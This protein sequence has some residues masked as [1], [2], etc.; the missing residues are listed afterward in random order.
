MI[1]YFCLEITEPCIGKGVVKVCILKELSLTPFAI[2]NTPGDPSIR[3][4]SW[5]S[6][7][8]NILV[9]QPE[10]RMRYSQH[11]WSSPLSFSSPTAPLIPLPH[12]DVPPPCHPFVTFL[13][14]WQQLRKGMAWFWRWLTEQ[15]VIRWWP[16]PPSLTGHMTSRALPPQVHVLVLL[17]R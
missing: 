8:C 3:V 4:P 2:I 15:R 10:P 6:S 14:L 5:A 1:I 16:F 7:Y 9:D 13:F 17:F 11:R 12:W